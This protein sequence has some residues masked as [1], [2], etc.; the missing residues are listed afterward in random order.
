MNPAKAVLAD[1]RSRIR[2]V[3]ALYEQLSGTADA[4]HVD[5]GRYIGR[6]AESLF[7]SMPR[8]RGMSG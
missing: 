8:R 6:L 5:L 7:E 2:S 3:A 1:T 4:A